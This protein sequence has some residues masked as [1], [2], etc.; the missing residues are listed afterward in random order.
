MLTALL[1]VQDML[2]GVSG[3]PPHVVACLN[4]YESLQ[5]AN[6]ILSD[7]QLGKG[8]ITAELLQPDE[9]V[10]GMLLQVAH[11]PALSAALSQLIDG[12]R[13]SRAEIYLR[14][15]ELYGLSPGR[16]WTFAELTELARL[17]GETCLGYVAADRSLVLAPDADA[18]Y[19]Y[20]RDSRIVVISE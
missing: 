17:R 14:R 3:P 8:R 6:H 11:E 20:N 12:T 18:G 4:H 9:L 10:S 16:R 19:S 13:G 7:R 2:K 1:V 15:P 5:T